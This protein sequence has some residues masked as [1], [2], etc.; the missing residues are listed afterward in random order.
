MIFGGCRFFV[1]FEDGLW[2]LTRIAARGSIPGDPNPRFANG[3]CAFEK[4]IVT[5]S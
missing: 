5:D 1:K 3:S 4:S 2:K